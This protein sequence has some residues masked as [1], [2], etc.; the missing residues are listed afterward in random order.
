MYVLTYVLAAI[1]LFHF[2]HRKLKTNQKIKLRTA[3]I[4]QQRGNM[5]HCVTTRRWR[6]IPVLHFAAKKD[7]FK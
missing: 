6:G 4:G 2:N 5:V 7:R 3:P 1:L